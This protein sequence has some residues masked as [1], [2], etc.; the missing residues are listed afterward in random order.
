MSLT[1]FLAIK[2]VREKFSQEFPKPKFTLKKDILVSPMTKHFGLVGTAFDYLIRFY[3]KRINPKALSSP[4]VAELVI[5][6]VSDDKFLLGKTKTIISE[7]KDAYSR[8]LKSGKM[9]NAVIISAILL[10]QLDIIFRCGIFDKNLGK[11]DEE[12]I[13]DLRNLISIVDPE[14]FKAKRLCI[15]NPVFGNASGL[16]GGADAD[17]VID[18]CLIDIKTTKKMELDRNH[19][20]Q[21][22]GYYV[23]S[24]IGSITGAPAGHEIDTIGIYYSRYGELHTI[25]VK[26]LIDENRLLSFLKWFVMRASD[27]HY[28]TIV[29]WYICLFKKSSPN[30]SFIEWFEKRTAEKPKL[31]ILYKWYKKRSLEEQ[32]ILL[33]YSKG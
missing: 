23:L 26:N 13:R 22:I 6:K 30:E 29:R 20:N 3:I 32:N 33:Q 25:P 10:S 7:A 17:L 4:W 18:K 2:D 24:R 5:D 8:Y 12:D 19:F 31:R 16:V 21:I 9:N 28:L 27:Q 1:S 15:L 11:A 14:T